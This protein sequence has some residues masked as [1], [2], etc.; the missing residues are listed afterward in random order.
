M[1]KIRN[2]KT[3]IL[4]FISLFIVV[5]VIAISTFTDGNLI[6]VYNSFEQPSLS[7][8][9]GTDNMGRDLFL[10]TIVGFRNTFLYAL[11]VQIIPFVL[12]SFIGA[13]LGYYGSIIDEVLLHFFNIL[14][15]FPSI[16][17]AIF[18]SVFVGGGVS[19]VI[20]IFSIYGLIYNI[21][22]V[23]AEIGQ[24]KNSDF[25]LGLRLNG[26][27]EKKI[28]FSHMIPRAFFILWPLL[29]LLIGHTMI[30]LSSFSFLGL[31]VQPPTPELGVILK[32]SLRFANSFPHM[33]IFPGLFQITCVLIFT[34]FSDT[35]N[36][37]LRTRRLGGIND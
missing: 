35:L 11:L 15:S 17:A 12:G 36:M 16:L 5:S 23:R 37:D 27:S 7:H 14:L 10:R 9:F 25:V 28:L 21:K 31:G 8:F 6:S 18:L 2:K 26:I 3:L 24:V 30:G 13:F 20:M 32:D 19:V 29:P 22:L 34:L 1:K 4:G 33:I